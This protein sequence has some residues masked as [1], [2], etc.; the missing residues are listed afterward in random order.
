MSNQLLNWNR[1]EDLRAP[2][3]LSVALQQL[4]IFRIE[5][6]RR[7]LRSDDPEQGWVTLPLW[8]K[9][10]HPFVERVQKNEVGREILKRTRLDV[11]EESARLQDTVFK[12]N[13]LGLT[14]I[15]LP[16]VLGGTRIGFIHVSGFVTEDPAP[17]DV[18]L[19]ERLRVLMLPEAEINEAINEWRTLPQFSADKRQ[20]VVQMLE[21]LCRDIVQFFEE[22]LAAKE[23]EEAVSRHTFNQL[24]T[25]FGPLRQ[26]LKRLQSISDSESTVL[27]YGESGTGRELLAKMIHERSTRKDKAFKILHCSSVAENLLE[28]ELLGYEKGSFAG[29]YS[30]KQGLVELCDGGTLYLKEIGDLSLSMQLKIL[31]II[32]DHSYTRLGGNEILKSN[33]RIIASTGRNLRKLIQKIY[34]FG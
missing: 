7:E 22:D 11:Q 8:L 2:R 25:T 12:T 5:V 20:I 23:R 28:A 9:G 29:A 33:V 34:S 32:E 3:S 15:C 13:G 16:I 31:K 19:Q 24:V 14:E 30:T 6:T 4:G 27:I 17:G 21:I 26:T 1:L 18:V 10:V